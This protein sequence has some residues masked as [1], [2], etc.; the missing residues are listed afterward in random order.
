MHVFN[1]FSLS[2][3]LK[4]NVKT[5]PK[6]LFRAGVPLGKAAPWFLHTALR[7]LTE[8]AAAELLQ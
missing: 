5:K 8:T 4:L 7:S 2:S 1:L 6:L 3:K